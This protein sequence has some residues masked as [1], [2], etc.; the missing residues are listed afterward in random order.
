MQPRFV[1]VSLC[2]AALAAFGIACGGNGDSGPESIAPSATAAQEPAGP[3]S[4]AA[5]ET[6]VAPA[7]ATATPA[8]SGNAVFEQVGLVKQ[9][10]PNSRPEPAGAFATTFASS[11]QRIDLVFKLNQGQGGEV[12]ASWLY[13]DQWLV[14]PGTLTVQAEAGEWA[15]FNFTADAGGFYAGDYEVILAKP[16]TSE[17]ISLEFSITP[18]SS[19]GRFD[20]AGLVKKWDQSTTPESSEFTTSFLPGDQRVY[21]VFSLAE[22][23]SG[24]VQATWKYGGEVLEFGELPRIEVPGGE[25]GTQYLEAGLLPQGDYESVVTIV[26]T[27]ETRSLTFTVGPGGS[28][29]PATSF[30]QA[31]VVVSINTGQTPTAGDFKTALTTADREVHAVFQLSEAADAVVWVTA[32][33]TY[34]GRVISSAS[35]SGPVRSGTW[36]GASLFV[37]PGLPPGDYEVL[38][39]LTGTGKTESLRFSVK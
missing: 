26:G 37:N 33:W 35:S 6:P 4:T 25:W 21:A 22:N 17:T 29:V 8:G 7:G 20:Q 16:G 31:G 38:L 18:P 1:I 12:S 19:N 32:I 36:D 28:A 10:D 11:D 5:V 27:D 2:L 3:S 30:A 9:W 15:S 24:Q 39:S 23:S 13:N 34:E 14:L